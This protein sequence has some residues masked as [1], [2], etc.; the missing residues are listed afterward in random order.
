MAKYLS[1]V[2][3][4]AYA[5]GAFA[6]CTDAEYKDA[7][8]N[9]GVCITALKGEL[10]PVVPGNGTDICGTVSTAISAW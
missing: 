1:L 3:V 6:E 5:S 2:I 4:S 8:D 10:L 9:V 7:L